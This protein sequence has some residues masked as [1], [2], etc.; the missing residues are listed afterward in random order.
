MEQ[1]EPPFVVCVQ[2]QYLSEL[3]FCVKLHLLRE[4]QGLVDLD[5]QKSEAKSNALEMKKEA[6]QE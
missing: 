3:T 1:S 5:V 4:E 2:M 6:G